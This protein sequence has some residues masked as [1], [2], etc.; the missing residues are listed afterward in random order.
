MRKFW[1]RAAFAASLLRDLFLGC[2]WAVSWPF[3]I[4]AR[5]A[6]GLVGLCREHAGE[7]STAATAIAPAP[8][9]GTPLTAEETAEFY[10][11]GQL[12]SFTGILRKAPYAEA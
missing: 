5:K 4:A 9:R 11:T 2:G 8:R 1:L 6:D 7:P 12:K 3:R 10:R